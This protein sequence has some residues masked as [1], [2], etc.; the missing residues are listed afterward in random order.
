MGKRQ[1]FVLLFLAVVV[2]IL[3][4]VVP[5]EAQ[6]K[7]VEGP[8]GSGDQYVYREDIRAYCDD[9]I[10]MLAVCAV[11]LH[12]SECL[13]YGHQTNNYPEDPLGIDPENLWSHE[14]GFWW[15]HPVWGQF[16]IL[17]ADNV[18]DDPAVHLCADQHGRIFET[19]D[20]YNQRSFKYASGLM[21]W[22]NCPYPTAAAGDPNDLISDVPCGE[23]WRRSSLDSHN[24]YVFGRTMLDDTGDAQ[25]FPLIVN[26]FQI[27][28][29][30][31]DGDTLLT[32][33]TFDVTC[34]HLDGRCE[35]NQSV[36]MD[37]CEARFAEVIP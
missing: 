1:W 36:P 6:T 19:F 33:E 2:A 34:A 3:L 13:R 21:Y 23:A 17:L 32:A 31:C 9:G 5:A 24:T 10:G 7:G 12:P 18:E 29:P 35:L 15:W 11:G 25:T 20:F 16:A 14:G 37:W 28:A 30:H 4:V 26:Q 22:A 27:E 8:G